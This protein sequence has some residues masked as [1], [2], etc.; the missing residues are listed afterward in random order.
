MK[1]G[2]CHE[3]K[4]ELKGPQCLHPS[5]PHICPDRKRSGL[6]A[7]CDDFEPR[8]DELAKE[9]RKPRELPTPTDILAAKDAE[10]AR[11]E[12]K[13]RILEEQN[14]RLWSGHKT[15]DDLIRESSKIKRKHIDNIERR[16]KIE[17]LEE[18]LDGRK[19]PF[20]Y[21]AGWEVACELNDKLKQLKNRTEGRKEEG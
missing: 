14:T 1:V 11:L 5:A 6:I 13:L 16:A 21:E 19:G 20:S 2:S 17:V 18:V 10:I 15:H 7:Q 12:E 3:C 9:Y 4:F 8:T